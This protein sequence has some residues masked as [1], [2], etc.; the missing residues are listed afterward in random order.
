MVKGTSNMDDLENV[1]YPCVSC[2]AVNRIPRRRLTEDPKCGRCHQKVFPRGPVQ[3]T[4]D[5]WR[6]EVEDCPIPVL[7]DFWAPWCAPCR[8]VGPVLEQIAQ[9][10]AGRLKIAKVNI[11]E[12]P[13][14]AN[15]L[16]VRSI[17]TMTLRR[18]PLHLDQIT[19]AL[20]KEAVDNWLDRYI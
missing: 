4:D 13:Q 17:P 1:Q 6:A 15:R 3:V 19:G 5:S 9:E 14:M 12:N 8:A 16:G 11:D 18:G 7:I 2:G 20:A 10:R